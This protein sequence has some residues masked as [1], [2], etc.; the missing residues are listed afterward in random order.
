MKRSMRN[1]IF[2][3]IGNVLLS[4]AVGFFL[5]PYNILSGGVAGIAV[6]IRVF[7]DVPAEMIANALV[8][9]LFFVGWA[10]LGKKFA[11]QTG[12]SSFIYPL[13]LTMVT[14]MVQP[15]EID[16]LLASLYG[17]LMAGLGIG[18]VIR[19][20]ASTGGMDIPPLIIHK[21]TH[22]PIASLI[23]IVDII[24]VMFG[25]W[26]YDLQ[27]VLIG[28]VSVFAT[29]FAIDKVLTFGGQQSKSI[30]IIS[31]SYE[32]I[33]NRIHEVLNRGTTILSAQGGYTQE[34]K[35]VI[36]VAVAQNEYPKLIDLINEIDKKAFIITNDATEVHGEGFSFGYRV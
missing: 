16:P 23:L 4:F 31:D 27:S 35:K 17:G 11:I 6:L 36:L 32:L 19:S 30:Q 21:Y 29:S 1:L 8:I 28:F 22:I 3:I 12:I 18:L 34:E 25:L 9:G 13:V 20:G 5:I 7:V 2:I 24:T 10:F 26:L 14:M 15:S 33:S